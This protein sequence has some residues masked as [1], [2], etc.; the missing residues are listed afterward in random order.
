MK[1]QHPMRK[2]RHPRKPKKI[3]DSTEN[4]SNSTEKK[5]EFEENLCDFAIT[6]EPDNAE[7]QWQRKTA[8]QIIDEDMEGPFEGI[9]VHKH[10]LSLTSLVIISRTLVY[11]YKYTSWFYF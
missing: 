7:F 1:K 10:G 2:P 9:N 3:A 5:C 6:T 4:E 11:E 8:R